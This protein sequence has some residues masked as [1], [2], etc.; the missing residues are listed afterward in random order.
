[1]RLETGEVGNVKETR[2]QLHYIMLTSGRA[3]RGG[4][5][6]NDEEGNTVNPSKPQKEQIE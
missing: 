2:S 6:I 5:T 3:G 4:G 1:M